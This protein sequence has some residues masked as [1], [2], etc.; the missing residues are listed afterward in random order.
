MCFKS[1]GEVEA[2]M[3]YLTK[4]S[5]VSYNVMAVAVIIIAII[6]WSFL[7]VPGKETY[8]SKA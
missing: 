7:Y 4:V 3:T 1:D 6:Y 8:A 5:W 2:V